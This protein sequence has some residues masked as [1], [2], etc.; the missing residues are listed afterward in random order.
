MVRWGPFLLVSCVW[1]GLV[2]RA[3]RRGQY[4]RV[5]WWLG[6]WGLSA[7]TWTPLAFSFG[8]SAVAKITTTWWSGGIWVLT[9]LQPASIDT[10]FW[11]NILMTVP[12][13]ILLKL[14]W[15]HLAWPSWLLAGLA[16][17]LTL[18]GGQAIGNA[19]VSLG[20][21]VDI[22]DVLTN[23]TGVFLGAALMALVMKCWPT[24][25]N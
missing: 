9:P 11:L 10:S 1:F 16:T 13:G 15:P 2:V 18:E 7:L 4:R 23:W 12:Q 20:R 24:K 17:G 8:G 22:N 14:N 6:C 25:F 3:W 5:L 19:L 21:W